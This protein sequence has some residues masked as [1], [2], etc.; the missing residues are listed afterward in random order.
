VAATKVLPLKTSVQVAICS[1]DFSLVQDIL[2]KTVI[3]IIHSSR[4][5]SSLK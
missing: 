5:T 1:L 3:L 4:Y 2:E